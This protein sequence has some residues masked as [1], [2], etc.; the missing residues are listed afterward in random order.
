MEFKSTMHE[1]YAK[2]LLYRWYIFY[3][4]ERTEQTLDNQLS[5]LDHDFK[6]KRD[7][8]VLNKEQYIHYEN[9]RPLNQKNAHSVQKITFTQ[10]EENKSSLVADIIYQNENKEGKVT[11]YK[12]HYDTILI[13]KEDKWYF[14]EI[15]IGSIEMMNHM[16]EFKD[17]YAENRV[18]SLIHYYLSLMEKLDGDASPFQD[19][20]YKDFYMKVPST[21]DPIT[22]I[23]QFES[24]LSI[25]KNI[26][27]STHLV[28][29]LVIKSLHSNEYHVTMDFN[30]QALTKSDK[31]LKTKSHQEW[32][33]VDT[34]ETFPRL[35]KII[36][37]GIKP[38]NEL[39]R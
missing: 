30:W 39:Q 29:N 38:L 28:E 22:N 23:D 5:I 27:V 4:R 9:Q 7:G 21:D 12:V 34:N 31:M 20:F 24:W 18:K 33:I 8:E 25:S 1:Q 2:S 37:S 32:E 36:I 13:L 26:K 16:S 10:V 15:K 6:V 14:S 17:T 35:K 19:I 11:S 3:E